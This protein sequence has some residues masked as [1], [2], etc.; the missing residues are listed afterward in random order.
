MTRTLILAHDLGTSGNKATLFDGE[1]HLI[2]SSFAPYPTAYPQPNWAE[3]NPDDWWNAVCSTTR[4]LLAESGIAADEIAAVGFS[5]MMMGCLPVDGD[6]TPLR[7]C[8]IWADQRAQ[9]EA[10]ALAELCGAEAIYQRCGHRVS[11]AYVAPKI[12]WL[13]AHQPEIYFQTARFLVPKDYIVHRLTGACATDYSDASG[14]LLFDLTTRRWDASILDKL[15]LDVDQLPFPYPSPAVVGE[16]TREAAEATGLAAGTPVVIGGG[17]GACAGIGAGVVEPGAAYC[18]IGTS[19]WIS[20][21]TLEP[22]PDAQQR[23]MTFH[24]V[25]PERYAPMGVQQ[26]AGG[27]REWAWRALA[28]EPALDLDSI[29]ADVAPGAAGLLFLPHLMGERSPY[30][31]PLARGAFVGLAMPHGKAE[32]ARAVLEGVGFGLQ[33]ILAILQGHVAG[34]ESL[35]L[36]GGGGKSRLW[37]QILADIFGLPIEMLELKAEA[38]SWGA[39]VAAGVGVG[40]YDWTIAAERSRVV[41][42]IAPNRANVARYAELAALYAEAYEALTPIHARLAHLQSGGEHG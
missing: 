17:D 5:G 1:G 41:E 39:A 31:N 36:I 30:W 18:V 34:I 23:T 24:H 7:S 16:V 15:G 26:L 37:Q 32:M 2:A 14:T 29:A 4:A 42:V 25:H 21:S 40:L 6:G 3:Q 35:R 8:I 28:G 27:A 22:V 38:T 10:T 13:R 9:Q 20:V 19:A 11:P 12:L 33:Q